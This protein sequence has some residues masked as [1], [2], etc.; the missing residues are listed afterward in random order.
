MSFAQRLSRGVLVLDGGLATELAARGHD[1]GDPLWS[2]RLLLDAPEA[3][4]EVHRAWLRAGA[5]V[6]TSASY[7]ASLPGLRARGLDRDAA[8][9]VL[10][11]A[12]AL[13]RRACALERPD[14]I[15]A[16]SAGSYGA[17]LADGSEYTGA[18]G[19]IDDDALVQF[20]RERLPGFADAD[21]IA[22]ET[23]PSA[24][25]AAAIA[26]ALAGHRGPPAWLSL[27]LRE[28]GHSGA[29]DALEACVDAI[30]AC[31]AI[32]AIG[33]NCCDPEHV[34]PALTR[35]RSRT[36]LPLLAYPNA[37]ERYDAHARCFVG[38][39][40]TPAELAALAGR[41]I[42]AG[43]RMVGGCCRTGPVDIAALAAVR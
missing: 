31:P 21:V 32:V 40:R 18:F 43:A 1:L 39:A 36:A 26:R 12:V 42:A 16:A 24:R 25:E 3:I 29:G 15:V 22:F 27:Q 7:Q 23:I 28:P 8:I 35:L 4:V 13:A 38:H 30:A 33:V 17:M 34:A 9:A 2:A 14:A 41:W 6:I 19:A 20:H 11:D 37:G 5:D 10:R